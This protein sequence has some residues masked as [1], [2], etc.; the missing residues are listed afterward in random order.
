MPFLG[1]HFIVMVCCHY[2]DLHEAKD[3]GVVAIVSKHSTNA[4]VTKFSKVA[5]Q[6]Y[7]LISQHSLSHCIDVLLREPVNPN[8]NHVNL[9]FIHIFD[10]NVCIC[11]SVCVC[12]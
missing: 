8:L 10:R 7:A 1:L 9:C 11:M 5:V 6:Y 3:L 12:W 2:A 4:C